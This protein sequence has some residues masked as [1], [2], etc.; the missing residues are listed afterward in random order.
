MYYKQRL[1][2]EQ[3]RSGVEQTIADCEWEADQLDLQ[4]RQRRF[5]V[6]FLRETLSD[7]RLPSQRP[8][9]PA[10][11]ECVDSAPVA[12]VRLRRRARHAHLPSSQQQPPVSQSTLEHSSSRFESIRRFESVRFDSLCESINQSIIV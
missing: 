1:V 8:P 9:P 11:A 2:W 3:V 10:V 5:I 7:P 6:A 12:P 4:L